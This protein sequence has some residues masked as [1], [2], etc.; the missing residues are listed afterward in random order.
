MSGIKC[1]YFIVLGRYICIFLIFILY[2]NKIDI[3]NIHYVHI[4]KRLNIET[5]V[6]I[7]PNKNEHH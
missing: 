1:V 4:Y 3:Q 7:L 2:I 5:I 6:S